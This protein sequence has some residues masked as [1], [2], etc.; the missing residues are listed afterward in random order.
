MTTEL[1]RW[2]PFRE[3]A[4]LREDVERVI[5]QLRM[6]A[7][8]EEEQFIGAWSLDLDVEETDDTYVLHAEM[9]GVKPGDI[10]VK[11]DEGVLYIEAERK[12]YEDKAAEGF[13]RVERRFG[14]LHR[15]IRLPSRV[16]PE[17]IEATY[18]DGLL[19]VTLRKTE[20]AKARTIPVST[21]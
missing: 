16:D 13:R 2:E 11:L 4:A 7:V 9:P 5:R 18:K 1:R 3:L 15:A 21:G 14:Q 12:F 8:A 17:K 19:T 6:P 10:E 20:D